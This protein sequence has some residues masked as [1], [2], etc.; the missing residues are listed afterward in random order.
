LEDRSQVR[1]HEGSGLLK[2]GPFGGL[3]SPCPL[4]Y[5]IWRFTKRVLGKAM[6]EGGWA[7][8]IYAGV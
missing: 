4:I 7:T 3:E 6:G 5:R 2:E 1:S 8:F